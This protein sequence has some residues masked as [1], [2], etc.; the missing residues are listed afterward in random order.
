MLRRVRAIRC[1]VKIGSV[2]AGNR[3]CSTGRKPVQT[4]SKPFQVG[5]KSVCTTRDLAYTRSH[6]FTPIES[7]STPA[8]NQSTPAQT[9]SQ[10]K[11]RLN[12]PNPDSD[13]VSR[14]FEPSPPRF[15]ESINPT[16]TAEVA[17][18]FPFVKVAFVDPPRG[19]QI[20]V[21]SLAADE[22]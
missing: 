17:P 2:P 10:T 7:Q 16:L 14:T 11:A 15:C 22:L 3:F 21:V 13:V 18:R 8:S 9:Q 20:P 12:Q 4:S 5:W 1:H 19:V 6:Q